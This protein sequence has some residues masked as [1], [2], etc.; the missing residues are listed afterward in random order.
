MY[1]SVPDDSSPPPAASI[2]AEVD[3]CPLVLIH[4]VEVVVVVDA[5]DTLIPDTV[6]TEKAEG[7]INPLED[8]DIGVGDEDADALDTDD[9]A[10]E[11]ALIAE[12]EEEDCGTTDEDTAASDEEGTA[13]G[14]ELTAA[15]AV[16]V[17]EGF[18]GAGA[19]AGVEGVG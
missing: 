10:D 11:T 4:S 12:D 18:G 7:R 2:P 6:D 14:V 16:D 1:L 19:G 13:G 15:G 5:E 3:G 8:S 9:D 17:E